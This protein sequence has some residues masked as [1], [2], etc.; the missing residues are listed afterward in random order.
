VH[1]HLE[2]GVLI[3]AG[4]LAKKAV[5]K[6][7]KVKPHIKTSLAP[8]IARRHRTTS[9]PP[10]LLESLEKVGFFVAGYGCTTCIG[11][12][13]P[14]A[15][16]IEEADRRQRP[17]LRRRA[18]GQPQLRGAHPRQHPRQLPRLAAARG[19]LRDRRHGAE[20]PRARAVGMGT[21]GPV[22]LKDIWPTSDEI[23]AHLKF[24]QDPKVYQKLYGDLTKDNPLWG[25][26][27][28]TTGQVY[29]WPKSTYIARAA[30]LRG[31]GM[32]AGKGP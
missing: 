30:V 6:G 18:L 11:N 23:H 29:D 17:R 28:A 9:R 5:A 8:G 20:G 26:D 24:A 22:M 4:L 21:N 1:Q 2:P 3:A 13:G 25:P 27:L 7:L 16:S 32:S 12:A 15:E 10:G 31:F 14:L 19:R